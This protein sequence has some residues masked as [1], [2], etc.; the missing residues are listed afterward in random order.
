M[1]PKT[2]W[3]KAVA[4]RHYSLSEI[5]T[6]VLLVSPVVNVERVITMFTYTMFTCE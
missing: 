2:K 5:I 3:L 4:R 6:E 1:P